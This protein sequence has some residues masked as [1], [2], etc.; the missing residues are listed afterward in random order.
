MALPSSYTVDYFVTVWFFILILQDWWVAAVG[1]TCIFILTLIRGLTLGWCVAWFFGIFVCF[2]FLRGA[3][4][5]GRGVGG[6]GSLPLAFGSPPQADASSLLRPLLSLVRAILACLGAWHGLAVW[7]VVV[8]IFVRFGLTLPLFRSGSCLL[9]YRVLDGQ[10]HLS[11]LNLPEI[12]AW[13]DSLCWL[14]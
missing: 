9:A 6:F 10:R 1:G 13:K 7:L 8:P 3:G 12:K 5:C 14:A 4:S 11:V 2:G